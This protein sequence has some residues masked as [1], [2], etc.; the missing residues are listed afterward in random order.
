MGCYYCNNSIINIGEIV[1]DM[2]RSTMYIERLEKDHFLT[3]ECG[4]LTERV[5]TLKR[6]TIHYCP[7]CGKKFE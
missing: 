2:D 4:D 5:G 1:E 3:L 7:F 6:T